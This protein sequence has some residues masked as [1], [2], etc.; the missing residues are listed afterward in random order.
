ML[1]QGQ[2]IDGYIRDLLYEHDCVI[3]MD[4]GGFI[5][6]YHPATINESL[7]FITPPSKRIAFNTALRNND[8]LLAHHISFKESLSY[9]EACSI[10]KDY[11]ANI[12]SVMEQGGKYKVEKV[13]VLFL[14][15]AG[16]TQFLPDSSTNFLADSFGLPIVQAVPV[17]SVEENVAAAN[18]N[19]PVIIEF[20]PKQGSE[21]S[22]GPKIKRLRVMEMI[23][24]AAI[25]ALLIM[26]PPIIQQFN[27]HMGSLVPFSRIDELVAGEEVVYKPLPSNPAPVVESPL[28]SLSVSEPV[29]V[30]TTDS[31]IISTPVVIESVE[32]NLSENTTQ[33]VVPDTDNKNEV[34]EKHKEKIRT[35]SEEKET[36]H[37]RSYHIIVGSYRNRHNAKRMVRELR[38]EGIDAEMIK[39]GDSR[40]L[41]TVFSAKTEQEAEQQ[42]PRFRSEVIASAWVFESSR[43]D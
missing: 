4:L 19:E 28:E 39:R 7:R 11:A 23:P 26:A 1:D 31:T 30:N 10:V 41:V 35:E 42:L 9:N 20:D 13:G 40:I 37:T 27:T 33:I 21:E 43:K 36:L 16:N 2:K 15:H 25:L 38:K 34:A 32:A 18:V 3:V 22:A 14:D 24:A 12:K 5:A 17:V 8:G 29:T 6:H